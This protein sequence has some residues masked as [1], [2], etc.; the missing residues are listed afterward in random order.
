MKNKKSI[1][2]DEFFNLI[3]LNAG[4]MDT[5][6]VRDVYYGMIKTISRELRS[7]NTVK[8]PDWGEFYIIIQ[9]ARKNYILNGEGDRVL[10]D[11]PPLPLVKFSP[12]WKVK[13]YFSALKK[14]WT[15]L[16]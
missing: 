12:D 5:R 9:K 6:V 1:K 11:Q 15:M 14:E 7:K 4:I 13:K 8:L 2:P 10:V 3:A 16:K